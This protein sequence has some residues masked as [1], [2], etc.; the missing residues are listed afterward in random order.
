MDKWKTILALS[1]LIL[2]VIFNW[3]WFWAVFIVLGLIHII[4]SKEIHFVESVS[5][6]ENPKL[7]S[8]MIVIWSCLALYS[9][10]NYLF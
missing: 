1:L 6:K 4:R 3:Q 10:V 8:I 5:L 9:I 7:Y 2:A